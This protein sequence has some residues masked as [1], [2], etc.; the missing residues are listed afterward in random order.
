MH[1]VLDRL[2]G[3]VVTLKQLRL[4]DVSDSRSDDRWRSDERLTLAREFQVLSSLHHP[5]IIS[6]LDYGFDE[7]RPYLTMDLEENARTIL[8]AARTEP[9]AMQVELLVQTLRALVYLHRHGVIHRDLKPENVLVVG[10]QVKVLDFGLSIRR[11]GSRMEDSEPAGTLLYMAPEILHGDPPSERS[12]LWAVGIMAYELLC[13]EHPFARADPMAFY[14]ELTQTTLPRPT[15]PVDPRL[16]P[17]LARLLAVKSA[18]RFEDATQVI[19]ALEKGLGLHLAVETLATRESFLQAAPLVGRQ[20]EVATLSALLRSAAA[21]HGGAWLIGGESG[22]GKSR[23]L[24][25]VR[26]QALVEGMIVVRGQGV[27]QVGGPYHV[28]RNV[29]RNLILRVDLSDGEAS[30]L[31]AV[32]P[33]I[34]DLLGLEIEDSLA[35][36]A[37]TTQSRLLLAVEEVLRRQG[38]TVL[39]ILEDLQWVGSES[40]RLLDWLAQSAERLPLLLLGTFRNDEAPE[41]ARAVESARVMMLGRLARSLA[42]RGRRASWKGRRRHGRE[43]PAHRERPAEG[44]LAV[45]L[46]GVDLSDGM[47][48]QCRRRLSRHGGRPMRLLLADA[49]ALPFG[50]RTFDRVFHVG[51]IG[52]Y[53]D[54][55]LGLAEMA[56]VARADTPIVVVDEQLD[57]KLPRCTLQRLAFRALTFYDRAPASPVGSLP[58]NAARIVDTQ[59]TDFYYCLSF[60]MAGTSP[61]WPC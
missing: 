51:G 10:D 2:T 48:E 41:L 4:R 15:D 52:A 13:G 28:W 22:V 36:N 9:L 14:R 3:R 17:I 44:I 39:V 50:D 21:G 42:L 45:E 20:E 46:W 37:E 53:H 24:D 38:G 1:R 59:L 27:S 6:V 25:E 30:A 56:R 7:Q 33:D 47:L 54:P 35:F 34:G 57:P 61:G 18:E 43:P 29:L 16:R 12:D 19:G 60:R 5:N 40:L 58:E 31:K 32:V 23:L 49:H 8:E 11:S 55:R 26:T